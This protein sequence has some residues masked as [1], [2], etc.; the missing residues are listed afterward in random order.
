MKRAA[1]IVA[2][3]AL[4]VLIVPMVC[5][6]ALSSQSNCLDG[7]EGYLWNSGDRSK[8]LRKF[9][10]MMDEI[11][12]DYLEYLNLNP[13]EYNI[14]TLEQWSTSNPGTGA[15]Y[16]SYVYRKD[17]DAQEGFYIWVLDDGRVNDTRF[18]KELE[19]AVQTYLADI[20]EKNYP[21]VRVLTALGFHDMPSKEWKE[22]DGIENFLNSDDDYLL[23][24]YV[25]YGTDVKMSES[26]VEA[27]KNEL[28][29]LNDVKGLFYRL[30]NADTVE[31]NE[32][33]KLDEE[34]AFYEHK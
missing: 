26:D 10:P 17:E 29:Y 27:I 14:D 33:R 11:P 31:K 30:D 15:A 12:R 22:S 7:Y 6:C 34:F 4:I 23:F 1:E 9:D 24:V 5:G 16:H 13:D 3:I 19:P 28:S 25:V 20:I 21:G 2:C 32:L 18:E 8:H